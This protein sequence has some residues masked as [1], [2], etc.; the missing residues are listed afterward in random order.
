MHGTHQWSPHLPSSRNHQSRHS[1]RGSLPPP[2]ASGSAQPIPP[3]L[4][5]NFS[6]STMKIG[7]WVDCLPLRKTT[8]RLDWPACCKDWYSPSS[9][10][11]TW[12]TGRSKCAVFKKRREMIQTQNQ[13]LDQIKS[14]YNRTKLEY[15]NEVAVNHIKISNEAEHQNLASK[16]LKN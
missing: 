14:N 3:E 1:G 7:L 9:T 2:P 13:D 6:I 10:W 15:K 4:Q 5:Q 16:M 12:R 8:I 11:A